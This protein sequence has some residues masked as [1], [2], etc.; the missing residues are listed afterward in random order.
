MMAASLNLPARFREFVQ[1]NALIAQRDRVIVAV[2]GGIDSAVLLHLLAGER[3]RWRMDLLVAHFNHRLRGAEADA[4]E[5]FARQL[6]AQYGLPFEAG[7]A[8]VGAIAAS[9]GSGIEEA[10][11]ALRYSFLE[12]LLATH[13]CTRIATGHNADDNAE[14]VLFHL[15]R[16][17]GLRGL[18]G[19]PLSR[20]NG[21][22]IRPLLFA[23]R[24]EI[25]AYGKK[26][27]VRFR[28]DTSNA[29]DDH[30]RNIIRHHILPVVRDR[31]QP[32]IAHTVLRTS[33][34]LRDVDTLVTDIARTGLDKPLTRRTGE[35]VL[36]PLSLLSIQPD[37]VQSA[38]I[39]EALSLTTGSRPGYETIRQ[40]LS[41]CNARAGATVHVQNGWAVSRIHA[42]L[43]I[44]RLPDTAPYALPVEC[45]VPLSV[46]GG[47]FVCE[48]GD[49]V[50]Y[51]ARPRPAG[52]YVDADRAGSTGLTLRSWR[53]GDRFMPLGMHRRK[54]LSDFFV[55]TGVPAHEKYRHPLLTTADGTIVWVC[56][57]RIDERFKITDSTTTVLR[58]QF[59]RESEQTHGEK[60]H[61]QR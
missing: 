5:A 12:D 9:R 60:P 29:S 19:I 49:R 24:S 27:G 39:V 56:G 3:K 38:M 20:N 58:L 16:G 28:E 50:L 13:S 31:I 11:R 51:D 25:A 26:A 23:S 61:R 21:I 17:S 1:R 8:D 41:L 52:E 45:N 54:K 2:S 4:D 14:T 18:A 35:E 32:D 6:A 15:F 34:L 30:T 55:D 7:R 53:R 40:I 59:Q 44:G 36:L 57:S 48:V 37:A 33:A 46:P 22:I 42:A 43:R 47:R 10:A